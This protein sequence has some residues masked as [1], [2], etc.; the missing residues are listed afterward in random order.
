MKSKKCTR[1]YKVLDISCFTIRRARNSVVSACKECSKV[2]RKSYNDKIKKL[3]IIEDMDGEIWKDVINYENFYQV[4]NFG[5]VKSLSRLSARGF[6]IQDRIL[7]PRLDGGGYHKAF[8]Y[9]N[10]IRKQY[11][12]HRLVCLHF[13]YRENSTLEVNHK[14]G[15]KNNNH[16]ENLEWCTRG[17]NISHAY[18]LGLK[19]N[20][21]NKKNR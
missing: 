15:N 5:R 3:F 21:K 18:K 19:K 12:I 20:L 16:L 13:L 7:T 10:S 14:D 11:S 8:L 9:K 4:S 1:C 6:M 17:Y 2:L